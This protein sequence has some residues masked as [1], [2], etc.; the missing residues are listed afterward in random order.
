MG[1]WLPQRGWPGHDGLSGD[2]N[3]L[4]RPTVPSGAIQGRMLAKPEERRGVV[5]R[6]CLG[7]ARA[8]GTG[9]AGLHP[10][11]MRKMSLFGGEIV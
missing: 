10:T 4:T 3:G 5:G 1:R 8:S 2:L 9:E 6:N 11:R 7:A